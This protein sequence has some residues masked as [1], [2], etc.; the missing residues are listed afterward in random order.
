MLRIGLAALALA[1]F[2][3]STRAE[4][5]PVEKGTIHYKPNDDQKSTPERYRLQE[6]KFDF[7]MIKKGDL[8]TCE[9]TLYHLT[10]PSP[11]ESAVKEN[12]T[13]HADFYLPKS[14]KPVA[15]AILLDITAGDTKVP[16]IIAAHLA[17]HGIASLFIQM[18]YYGPRRPPGCEKRLL[19]TDYKHSIEAVRQ[20]VLDIRRAAG[21]MESRKELDSKRLGVVGTSLGSFMGTLAAEMEPKLRRVAVLLGGGGLVDAY[22]EDPR[23]ADLRK[24]WEFLGGTKDK[25]KQMFAPVDPLTC[26]ENLK[27]RKLLIVAAKKDDIVPPKMAEALWNASGRQ[28]IVWFDANHF[29]AALCIAPALRHVVKLF[30]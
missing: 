21:W 1:A 26:A 15:C 19:S 3:P 28:E 22:Y 2:V 7:E 30:D 23:A 14:D 25:L 16:K 8:I 5:R 6:H 4:D 11:V 12:N 17:Q 9:G 18:P 24:M 13:V 10:F 27:D 29:T 20:T